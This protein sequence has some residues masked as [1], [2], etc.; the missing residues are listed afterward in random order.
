M[1]FIEA[2]G[3]GDD[4]RGMGVEDCHVQ[5]QAVDGAVDEG[6][7]GGFWGHSPLERDGDERSRIVQVGAAPLDEEPV[8]GP[9]ARV[10]EVCGDE[11]LGEDPSPDPR[12]FF[13]ELNRIPTSRIFWYFAMFRRRGVMASTM[14]ETP[15]GP[16][17][18]PA[19]W[20]ML[21]TSPITTPFAA[22][23]SPQ[24]AT[25]WARGVSRAFQD[26]AAILLNAVQ[27]LC[28]RGEEPLDELGRGAFRRRGKEEVLLPPDGVHGG[29]D[30]LSPRSP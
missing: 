24:T 18:K 26:P 8:A 25:E 2:E 15:R 20:G 22:G 3:E 19:R 6:F 17:S 29:D 9:H 28:L 16:A 23:S 14:G 13:A 4:V 1:I 5:G 11:P 30:H 27:T 12:E 7:P 10:P 21:S